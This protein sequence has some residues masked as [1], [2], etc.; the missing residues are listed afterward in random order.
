MQILSRYTMHYSSPIHRRAYL[1]APEQFV[2]ELIKGLDDATFMRQKAKVL[3]ALQNAQSLGYPTRTARM[4]A[5][6]WGTEIAAPTADTALAFGKRVQAEP[7]NRRN[8][9]F[10]NGLSATRRT[11]TALSV[12]K[13]I[14][15]RIAA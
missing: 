12:T 3:P 13:L 4:G 10:E 11:Q 2:A 7:R 5:A 1:V 15:L 8:I 9:D 14:Y 6:V